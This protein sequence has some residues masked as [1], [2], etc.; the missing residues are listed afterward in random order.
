MC[1]SHALQNNYL[2]ASCDDTYS[3]QNKIISR[4]AIGESEEN[5]GVLATRKPIP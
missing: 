5:Y 3:E 1:V 4:V 2:R